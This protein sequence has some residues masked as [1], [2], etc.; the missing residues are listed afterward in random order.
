MVLAGFARRDATGA[1]CVRGDGVI[2]MSTRFEWADVDGRS[3][4][5]LNDAELAEYSEDEVEPGTVG[6]SM[7]TGSNGVMLWG[8]RL[9]MIAW[10]EDLLTRLT[11]GEGTSGFG[12]LREFA[13]SDGL[14]LVTDEDGDVWDAE[15][16]HQGHVLRDNSGAVET[17]EELTG[18][19]WQV[20]APGR[21]GITADGRGGFIVPTRKVLD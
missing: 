14:H 13:F 20:M 17:G 10:A 3:A 15:Q 1:W 4:W 7:M 8:T 18:D 19:R 16:L 21:I 2:A 5:I 6:V 9:G 12:E 11:A